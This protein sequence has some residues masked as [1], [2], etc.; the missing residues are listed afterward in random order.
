MTFYFLVQL[1]DDKPDNQ[2]VALG[3]Q[4]IFNVNASTCVGTL[5]FQWQ[6]NGNNVPD[7]TNDHLIINNVQQ[8]DAG[9]YRCVVTNTAG[10]TSKIS[11]THELTV[12]EWLYYT[13][14]V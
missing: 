4:A 8:G 6:H 13:C 12:C 14:N 5:K 7:A 1:N 10:R 3:N 11:A 2:K 9:R